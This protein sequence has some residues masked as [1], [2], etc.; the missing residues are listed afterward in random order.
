MSVAKS[1]M[2]EIIAELTD[3]EKGKIEKRYED[4]KGFTKVIL[5][6][7]KAKKPIIGHNMMFDVLF[8]YEKFVA[9][10]PGSFKEF[11]KTWKS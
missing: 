7:K 4:M 10:L 9:P 2:E 3:E 5:E 6:L 8:T 1:R 11:A